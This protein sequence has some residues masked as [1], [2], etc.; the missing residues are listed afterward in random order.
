MSQRNSTS[1]RDLPLQNSYLSA[2][3]LP[4]PPWVRH[5]EYQTPW[6]SPQPLSGLLEGEHRQ[7]QKNASFQYFRASLQ[8]SA[9]TFLDPI[10]SSWTA[11]GWGALVIALVTRLAHTSLCTVCLHVA[12]HSA[13]ALPADPFCAKHPSIKTKRSSSTSHGSIP[14]PCPR[15]VLVRLTNKRQVTSKRRE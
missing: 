2:S 1:E 9:Q 15:K 5:P 14:G 3:T 4:S 13:L 11:R 10:P 8:A 7:S 12:Q 6:G